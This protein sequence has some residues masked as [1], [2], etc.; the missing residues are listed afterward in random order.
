VSQATAIRQDIERGWSSLPF[1]C[2]PIVFTSHAVERANRRRYRHL[3]LERTRRELEL[4][5]AERGVLQTEP[6]NWLW[7][8]NDTPLA[9]L[10][11]DDLAFP[12]HTES[13]DG[14]LVATTAIGR[15]DDAPVGASVRIVRARRKGS[16]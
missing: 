1:D 12:I 11:I 13:A 3:L 9:W 14:A 16:T 4:A 8:V 6:P 7:G 10:V 5:A 15:G 2:C